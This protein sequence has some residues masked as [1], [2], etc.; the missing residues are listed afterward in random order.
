MKRIVLSAFAI[1]SLIFSACNQNQI[2]AEHQD[3]AAI[4]FKW[5]M[6]DEKTFKVPVEHAGK[7]N[8]AIEVRHAQDIELGNLLLTLSYETPDGKASE[9]QVNF[10]LRT[11]EGKLI[12]DGMGEFFDTRQVILSNFELEKGTYT[13]K[14]KHRMPE[15]NPI[16]RVLEVGLVVEKVQ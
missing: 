10:T 14:V 13:F 4:G 16:P 8:V 6:E 11:P 2:F 3:V 12:G 9:E 7:Y 15:Q 1:F 5:K